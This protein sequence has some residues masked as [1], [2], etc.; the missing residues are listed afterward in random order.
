[1]HPDDG[2]DQVSRAGNVPIEVKT[3]RPGRKSRFEC[4]NSVGGIHSLSEPRH[5]VSERIVIAQ[6]VANGL[7]HNLRQHALRRVLR[8][9][10]KVIRQQIGDAAIIPEALGVNPSR[11]IGAL[12]ERI[13]KIIVSESR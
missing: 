1:M 9:S 10:L 2:I 12:A 6:K 7:D 11:T 4:E 5:H 8:F 13:A 3:G